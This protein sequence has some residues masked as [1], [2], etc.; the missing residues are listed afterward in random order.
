MFI[1]FLTE[2][3][4]ANKAYEDKLQSGSTEQK[5]FSL[6]WEIEELKS[7]NSE[8][9][10]IHEDL[11]TC[12]KFCTLIL[13]QQNNVAGKLTSIWQKLL[14]F[15]KRITYFKRIAATHVF[16][17]MI[18]PEMRD[19]KPYAVPV[20]CLPY[21]GLKEKDIRTLVSALCR[22]MVSYNMKVSGTFSYLNCIIQFLW[23]GFV[24]DGEFNY[25]RTKGYTRP[26]SVIQIRCNVR[27]KYCN[28]RLSHG[29][30]I[31]MLTPKG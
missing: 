11:M 7:I 31:A 27:N 6:I 5:M 28:S 25:L 4:I 9:Q 30:L 20:Q 16:V 19:R 24:T 21:N 3:K 26:L 13:F 12:T 8:G 18:S 17:F 10:R 14:Q 23:I 1:I 29:K 15:T 2:L 22:K